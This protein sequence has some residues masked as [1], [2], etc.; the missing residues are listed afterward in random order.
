[1]DIV[2]GIDVGATGIKGNLVNIKKGTLVGE[3]CKIATPNHSTPENIVKVIKKIIEHF[4]WE[5]KDIGIG[6]PSIISNGRTLSAANIDRK[7]MDFEAEKFF[8]KE[9]K[10]N[11]SLINDADAAGISERYHGAAKDVKG[12][13]I[14]L[15]LGT[16]IGSAIFRDGK[17]I[18]N[19]ELGHLKYKKS[20]TEHYAANSA[21]ENKGLKYSEWGGELENVLL[22]I[23][24]L[25]SP[26]L[27]ILGGGISKKFNKYEKYLS[28]VRAK[29]I[30]AEMKNEAGII[31]A[32][33]AQ[34]MN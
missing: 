30:A 20:I 11:L 2:L 22:Y 10:A 16:G 33:M 19:T 8:K 24:H 6:F 32:A 18:P 4:D 9:L 25:F 14:L 27:F 21:R 31:G 23:E 28:K 7:W 12:T 3:R 1:M 17:L 15:T 26:D 29:V 5:G 13:V 34:R